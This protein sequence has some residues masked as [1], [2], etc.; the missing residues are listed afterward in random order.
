MVKDSFGEISRPNVLI[1]ESDNAT[2]I[3]FRGGFTD[4]WVDD[5]NQRTVRGDLQEL[6]KII[7]FI[8]MRCSAPSRV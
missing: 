7:S 6:E 8:Q 2:V 5:R 4:D 3:D 1:Y